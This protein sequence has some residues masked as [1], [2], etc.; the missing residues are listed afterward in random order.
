MA[1][2]RPLIMDGQL[3]RSIQPGDVLLLGEVIQP[4][5]TVGAGT[6]TA[7]LVASGLIYRTGPTGA[8]TDTTDTAANII[9]Q[10]VAQY[11]YTTAATA[12]LSSG[13]AVQNGTTV[14]L[15]YMNSVAFVATIAAGTG[16]TLG[17]NA[18]TVNAS[19]V[20]DFLITVTN[21]TPQQVFACNTTNAS[22][23]VTGLTQFQTS[24]L[25]PG[26]L[27]TGTGISGG[28]TI[29]GIVNGVGVTL[30]ANA[31]AT[32]V[33]TALTFSPTLRVDGMGQGLL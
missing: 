1:Y 13:V 12:G 21:G 27:V 3:N 11:N 26:M 33:L 2:A 8:Y 31:T 16:V 15:R 4:L 24:L 29:A 18:T 14:R 6:L 7:L 9:N 17:N 10:I 5:T 19:S 22:A 23:V 28:T 20:K 30:S 32:N 25:T